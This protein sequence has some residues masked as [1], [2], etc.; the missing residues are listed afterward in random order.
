MKIRQGYVSNS[1]STSFYILGAK[2]ELPNCRECEKR[3][4]VVKA[5][6]EKEFPEYDYEFADALQTEISDN[7][8]PQ[9]DVYCNGEGGNPEL[10]VGEDI[11]SLNEDKT[12]K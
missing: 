11:S 2:I 8:E 1:S 6:A 3:C 10:F 12:I 4:D 7:R 5:I 9:M